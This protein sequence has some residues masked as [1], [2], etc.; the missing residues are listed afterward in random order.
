MAK[1]ESLSRDLVEVKQA[2]EQ[3][4]SEVR[5]SGEAAAELRGKLAALEKQEQADNGTT[6]AP[7]AG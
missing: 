1:L 5:A 4:R 3:A 2:A 7:S 6:K